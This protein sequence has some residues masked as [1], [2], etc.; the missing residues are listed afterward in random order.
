M[1]ILIA[2]LTALAMWALIAYLQARR[3]FDH[4]RDADGSNWMRSTVLALGM[5]T[6]F[7]AAAMAVKQP[8]L[9]QAFLAVLLLGAGMVLV[10]IFAPP[11]WLRMPRRT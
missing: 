10:G 6:I 9:R 3:A 2:F 5:V 1:P 4:G 11:T 8:D 7:G